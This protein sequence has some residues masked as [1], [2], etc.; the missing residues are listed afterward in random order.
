MKRNGKLFSVSILLAGVFAVRASAPWQGQPGPGGNYLKNSS[1]EQSEGGQPA[2]WTLDK[3]IRNRGTVSLVQR[4][5]QGGRSSLRLSPNGNNTASQL[6]DDPFGVGQGFPADAFRAKTLYFSGWV[7]ADGD[8]TAIVGLLAV[9]RDGGVVSAD[10]R[11]TSRDGLTFR[12]NSLA[13]PNDSRISF[14]VLICIV[15]GRGGNAYFD[16]VY[17]GTQPAPSGARAAAPA[18]DQP[19]PVTAS[20]NA[21]RNV[22]RN[23]GFEQSNRGL[24]EGWTLE[25]KVANKGTASMVSNPKQSGQSALKLSPNRNNTAT[26][27]T[28]DPFGVGQGYPAESFRGKTVYVSGW[29]GA[30]GGATAII[31]LFGLTQQGGLIATELRQASGS[32][33]L[34]Y[35]ENSLAI[36]D[37]RRIAF[38]IVACIV[39]G[40]SGSAYFDDIYVGTDAPS[41]TDTPASRP[42]T[43]LSRDAEIA[44][45]A[46][47]VIR[48]IPDG[49]FGTNIEWVWDGNGIWHAKDGALDRRV[50]QLTRDLRP[51]LIRFPGGT[52]SDFYHWRDGIGPQSQRKETEHMPGASRSRHVFGTDEA[53]SFAEAVGGELLITVNAGTGTAQEAADWVRYVNKDRR[54]VRYWEIGNELYVNDGSA[55]A[56]ASTMTPDRYARRVL[57]FA[58]AM[59][60]VDPSIKIGA[61]AEE[62]Y[63][64]NAAKGYRD[65][66]EQVLK[67]AGSKIDFLAVHNAYAPALFS[68]KN[69][70]VRTVYAAM[71]AA[72]IHIRESLKRISDKIE[73]LVPGRGSQ[74]AIAVTEWGPYFQ[75]TPDGRFVDHA[76]TL[77]SGLYVA[78]ALKTFIE[79]PHVEV[80]N[81]FKLVDPLFMGWIGKRGDEFR[82][83]GPYYATQMFTQHFGTKVVETSSMGP[84]YDSRSVGWADSASDVPYLDVVSSRSADDR[85]LYVMVINKHFDDSIRATIRLQDFR[86][87]GGSA[88]IMSGTGIDA[89]TGTEPFRAPGVQWAKQASA[90]R[91]DRGAVNEISIRHEGLQRVSTAFEFEF[92]K[93]SI[94][95]LEIDGQ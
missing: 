26:Q 66:T 7:G 58:E 95:S 17:L 16:D 63:S 39:H 84:T 61:I 92:P 93:H 69:V 86:P 21:E 27:L 23:P 34:R 53:L 88:W 85:K 25:P 90:G 65:W 49:L 79:S 72:P 2:G 43:P 64:L 12:E 50:I 73:N 45:R 56:K 70:D 9:T 41:S 5:V 13:L 42:S 28:D 47:N 24:P 89:N 44:V 3:K 14:V 94:V 52:F 74:I 82:P 4:P 67:T 77:G 1:F 38:L 75:I 48:A 87:T 31:G 81:A 51:S 91:F 37:D 36:P 15:H 18:D 40:T 46:R 6:T 54:R 68:D 11:Q 57:E 30:E 76:K 22:L 35:R 33:E 55:Q 78:T 83:T 59:R 19:L 32:A 62:N 71:L 80:A 10:L 60:K 29:I 20:R 8:A